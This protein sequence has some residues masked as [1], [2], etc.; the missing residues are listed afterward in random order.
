MSYHLS[1]EQSREIV[2]NIYDARGYNGATDIIEILTK[3]DLI[4]INSRQLLREMV[5]TLE[6]LDD[7]IK[8]EKRFVKKLKK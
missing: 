7:K 1:Y 8:Q 2:Y 3:G 6:L 5:N 4:N